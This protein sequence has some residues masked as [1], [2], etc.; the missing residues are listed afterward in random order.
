VTVAL[1][2]PEDGATREDRAALPDGYRHVRRRMRVGSGPAAFDSLAAGMRTW[3]IHRGAGLPVRA[4]GPPGPERVFHTG[5]SLG[6]VRLWAPCRIVWLA[7]EPRR[8]GYG[9]GTLPGHPERGEEAMIATLGGDGDV[10]FEIRAFSR[11]ATWYAR[12]GGPVGRFVQD[13][14]TDRYVAAAQ[15]LAAG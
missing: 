15:R 11:P 5:L 10:W 2:Y 6:P 12:L 8:F 13:R 1:T 14:V 3:G 9:F 4:E 7:D